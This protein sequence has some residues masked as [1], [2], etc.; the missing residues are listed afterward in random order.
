[1]SAPRPR[2]QPPLALLTCLLL[3]CAPPSLAQALTQASP[4]QNA[5][6]APVYSLTD[7]L[8]AVTASAQYKQAKLALDTAQAQ[9]Q[10]AQAATGLTAGVNAGLTPALDSSVAADGST[11][12]SASLSGTVGATLSL[13]LLPWSGAQLAAQSAARSLTLA[14]ATFAQATLTLAVNAEQAYGRGVTAQLNVEIATSQLILTQRQ[15]AQVRAFYANNNATLPAV[16]AAEAAVQ[17][18]QTAVLR[19]QAE[20]ES[21]RRALGNLVEQDL[22]SAALNPDLGASSPLPGQDAALGAARRFSPALAGAQLAVQNAQA[23][24]ATARRSRDVPA[25]SFTASYG[26]GAGTGRTGLSAGLNLTS[27]V[28]SVAYSQPFSRGSAAP[29]SSAT[30][31]ALGVSA[32]FNVLDPAADGAV[33]VAALQLQQAQAALSIQT[34]TT[35]QALKDAYSAAQ[36]AAQAIPARQT[37]VAGYTG[38]LDTARTRLAA[39]LATETEV[40]TAQIALSQAARDLN[41][42]QLAALVASA[43][44]A[45]LT[46]PSGPSQGP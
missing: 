40:L 21:A 7:T 12:A 13:P 1:M 14:R 15:L 22:N 28:G 4:P 20:G 23:T 33:K 17:D 5:S 11:Q 18:A 29:G 35:D 34:Q 31:F 16:Q 8:A 25:T 24:L 30:S 26:T 38:A 10:A 37:S 19:A 36:I 44:L 3:A 39:G 27:G 42:A 45:A 41:S 9:T 2:P 32:S 46:G 6:P 43:Q